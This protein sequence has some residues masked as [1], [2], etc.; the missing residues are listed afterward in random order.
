MGSLCKAMQR[1]GWLLWPIAV[2]LVTLSQGVVVEA[3]HASDSIALELAGVD[4]RE[5]E[6]LDEQRVN[7]LAQAAHRDMQADKQE[8]LREAAQTDKKKKKAAKKQKCK[9]SCCDQ[10]AFDCEAK[11]ELCADKA[12][13]KKMQSQCA[14]TCGACAKLLAKKPKGKDKKKA[15]KPGAKPPPAKPGAK[16]AAKPAAKAGAKS[17]SV[18]KKS[19]PKR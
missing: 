17:K 10:A 9:G 14:V 5:S 3:R 15:A 16:S 11:K 18:K 19:K 6:E 13:A 1:R 12:Y 7:S 2:V 8:Q 4:A